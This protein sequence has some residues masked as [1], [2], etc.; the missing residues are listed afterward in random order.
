MVVDTS[1]LLAIV[2][3]EPESAGL[4]ARLNATPQ[5]LLSAAHWLE[6]GIVIDARKG[7]Q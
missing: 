4:L 5:S 1:A 3:E 6:L 7:P 2:L